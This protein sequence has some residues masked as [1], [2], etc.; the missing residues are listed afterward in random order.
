M[1]TFCRLFAEDV[2]ANDSALT[3]FTAI[4]FS[5]VKRK[6]ALKWHECQIR[7]YYFAYTEFLTLL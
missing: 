6:C 2:P 7:V 3:G 5:I 4:S 1:D